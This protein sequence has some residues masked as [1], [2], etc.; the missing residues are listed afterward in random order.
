MDKKVKV[1][2]YFAKLIIHKLISYYLR[3]KVLKHKTGLIISF[4]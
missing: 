4:D 1:I 2:D 3:H